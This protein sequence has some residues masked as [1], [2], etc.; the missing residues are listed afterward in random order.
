M[1]NMIA[2]VAKSVF[3]IFGNAKTITLQPTN[4]YT[5][6][7]NLQNIVI[8]SSY[9]EFAIPNINTNVLMLPVNNSPK[10]YTAI[11]Y[12]QSLPENTPISITYGESAKC[13]DNWAIV[14]N[15]TGLHANKLDNAN[16]LATLISGE[17]VNYLMLNRIHELENMI[18]EI[19]SNYT[20]LVAWSKTVQSGS[21]AGV[22]QTQ[23][24][25]PG[26]LSQDTTYM[27]ND[28]DLLNDNATVVP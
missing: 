5:T 21:S 27:A 23:L 28:N 25:T 6:G 4:M 20:T 18:S 12:I 2:N 3:N 19:N 14:W 9:G 1:F 10:A 13:S 11:G 24:S 8:S 15:N 7:Y 17:W 22:T 26:T 16:Y